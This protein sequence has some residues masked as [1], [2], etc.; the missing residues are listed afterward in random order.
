MKCD[1]CG[2][3]VINGKC[4][5]CGKEFPVETKETPIVPHEYTEPVDVNEA[6]N[7]RPEK[8]KINYTR[9][10]TA[11]KTKK[12]NMGC[13]TFIVI[14]II[15]GFL[16][17]IFGDDDETDTAKTDTTETG[18]IA[19]TENESIWAE[20]YT[21][22]DDFDYY[23]DGDSLYLKDYNGKEKKV[24]IASSYEIEGVE[25]NVV[26]LKE[27]TFALHSVDSV[28][29]PEGVV[30]VENN[31][32]NSCGIEYVYLP[33]TLEEINST[34]LRYFHDVEKIYYGGTEEQW[35]SL[36]TCDRED[37]DVKQIIY[38]ANIDDLQ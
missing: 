14:I 36:V 22:I 38:E 37:I 24:S 27:G 1:A 8:R 32:F 15:I 31:T 10:K 5:Y 16:S 25:Y 19:T 34:F 21:S 13:G 2:A 30:S 11:P 26:A 12:K 35:N 6:K 20:N 29:I 17:A 4:I 9:P 33:S 23:I 3:D 18:D 28:I 7:R